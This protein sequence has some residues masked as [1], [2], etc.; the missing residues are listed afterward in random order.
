MRRA[1]RFLGGTGL[2]AVG[3]LGGPAATGQYWQGVS[4]GNYAGT[5]GVYLN[6]AHLADSPLKAYLHLGGYENYLYNNYLA[7][8]APYSLVGLMTNT[9]RP[10]YRNASGK[11]PFDGEAYLPETLNLSLIHI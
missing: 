11:I 3:L 9:V 2:L 6:P 1:L 4:A 10:R 7:W 8:G 5:Q